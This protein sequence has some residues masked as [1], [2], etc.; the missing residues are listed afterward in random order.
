MNA[1]AVLWLYMPPC[2]RFYKYYLHTKA[3]TLW[4]N[5]VR[6][7]LYCQQVGTAA[8]ATTPPPASQPLTYTTTTATTHP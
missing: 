3:F 8:M 1:D 7:K 5:N 6:F 4:K 2:T